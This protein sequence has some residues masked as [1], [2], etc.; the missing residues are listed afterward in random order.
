MLLHLQLARI[1]VTNP[2]LQG[3]LKAYSVVWQ[4]GTNRLS[5]IDTPPP[6]IPVHAPIPP[7]TLRF[8]LLHQ[9]MQFCNT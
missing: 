4:G 8:C 7:S 9:R 1:P 6:P 5:K 3:L 2:S